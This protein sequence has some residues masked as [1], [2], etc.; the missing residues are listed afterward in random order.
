MTTLS[1]DH[2]LFQLLKHLADADDTRY[3]V[4]EGMSV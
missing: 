4:P 1:V 3:S 2:K